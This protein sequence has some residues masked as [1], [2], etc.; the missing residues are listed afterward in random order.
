VFSGIFWDDRN[1]EAA[2]NAEGSLTPLGVLSAPR[3]FSREAAGCIINK[4][5]HTGP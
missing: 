5:N 2:E 1:A 3:R 4:I